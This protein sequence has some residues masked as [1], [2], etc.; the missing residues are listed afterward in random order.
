[1]VLLLAAVYALNVLWFYKLSS[2]YDAASSMLPEMVR[3]V[4][5]A[6]VDSQPRGASEV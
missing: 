2:R 3:V 4:L 1:M 6:V 5:S